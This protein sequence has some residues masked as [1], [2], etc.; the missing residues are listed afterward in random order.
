MAIEPQT[1]PTDAGEYDAHHAA[2]DATYAPFEQMIES[3]VKIGKRLPG[4]S[5]SWQSRRCGI[6]DHQ[7]FPATPPTA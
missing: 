1:V 3:A 4:V 5:P 7:G 6:G 2:S